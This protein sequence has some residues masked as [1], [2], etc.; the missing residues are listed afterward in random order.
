MSLYDIAD[1]LT[2]R[3]LKETKQYGSDDCDQDRH[4]P[5]YLDLDQLYYA[6]TIQGGNGR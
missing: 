2:R 5:E 1:R 4:E 3:V 6:E